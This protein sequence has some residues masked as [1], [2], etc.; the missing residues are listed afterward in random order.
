MA[1]LIPSGGAGAAGNA[2]AGRWEGTM[3]DTDGERSIELQFQV[4]AGHL[5]G[6][7]TT[8]TGGAAGIAIRT[9]LQQVTYEKGVL[10]FLLPS[11]GGARQFRGGLD[12]GTLAGSI[13]K[14]AAAKDA[15]GRFSLRYVE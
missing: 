5:N 6:V 12:G 7:L 10:K 8:K 1:L 9:P 4:D 13:F 3:A 11:G 14:D 2:V 15:V